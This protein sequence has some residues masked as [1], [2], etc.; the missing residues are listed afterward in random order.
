MNDY[1]P[2]LFSYKTELFEKRLT[3]SRDYTSISKYGFSEQEYEH[4]QFPFY[5]NDDAHVLA[6]AAKICESLASLNN[7][8][9]K[10]LKLKK[11]LVR[12]YKN[13]ISC[14][15]FAGTGERELAVAFT[16]LMF[17]YNLDDVVVTEI[18]DYCQSEDDSDICL[19]DN[20][21]LNFDKLY[22]KAGD[23]ALFVNHDLNLALELYKLAIIDWPESEQHEYSFSVDEGIYLEKMINILIDLSTGRLIANKMDLDELLAPD[24]Y[25]VY[26]AY[27]SVVLSFLDVWKNDGFINTL[28][29]FFLSVQKSVNNQKE[30]DESLRV[31]MVMVNYIYKLTFVPLLYQI[32]LYE[33]K[34]SWSEYIDSICSKIPYM[35]DSSFENLFQYYLETSKIKND[36]RIFYFIR[37]IGTV[38]NVLEQLRINENITNFAYYSSLETFSYMLPSGKNKQLGKLAVMNISYMNDPNEGKIFDSL[39]FGKNAK[40]KT[41]EGRRNIKVPYVFVKCFTTKIDYL[42]MWEMYGK[43]AEGCCLVIDW[44]K[45][46]QTKSKMWKSLYRVCYLH[47]KGNTFTIRKEE[48]P[49]ISDIKLLDNYIKELKA[50]ACHISSYDVEFFNLLL[51]ELPYL[52]KESSYSYEEEI[53]FLYIYKKIDKEFKHTDQSIPKLYILPEFPICFQEVIL[54]PKVTNIAEKIPYLQEQIDLMSEKT[55]MENPKITVS[56]IEYR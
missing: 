55:G 32:S 44:K 28:E 41:N 42:P 10:E 1:A 14:L 38:N 34:S 4:E 49:H 26:E 5:L 30:I 37:T 39:L 33:E 47:K 46:I 51:G 15:S 7:D 31:I 6:H 40:R 25:H 19:T 16:E 2:L 9:D 43:H 36:V 48:N 24:D 11:E 50:I 8:S 21:I 17:A 56:D 18:K 22:L 35:K 23:R 52:F 29:L 45:T 20:Q 13:Y 12:D 3:F 54:G 53:R 27:K